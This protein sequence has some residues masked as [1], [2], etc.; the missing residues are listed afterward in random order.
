MVEDG[1]DKA[2]AEENEDLIG[3]EMTGNDLFADLDAYDRYIQKKVFKKPTDEKPMKRLRPQ[4]QYKN[5]QLQQAYESWGIKDGP[6]Q[7]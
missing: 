3:V 7:C 6:K 1:R 2:L 5:L 4:E